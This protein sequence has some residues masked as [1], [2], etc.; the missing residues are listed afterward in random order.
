M[1]STLRKSRVFWN[2]SKELYEKIDQA[3]TKEELKNLFD[4]HFK[5]LCDLS[6]GNPHYIELN[7]IHAI[8]ETKHKFVK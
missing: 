5:K 3:K 4:N 6:M 2:T 1:V 7:R 8:I